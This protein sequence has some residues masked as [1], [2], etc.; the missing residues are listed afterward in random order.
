M[1]RK[2]SENVLA[3]ELEIQVECFYGSQSVA[4]K[5]NYCFTSVDTILNN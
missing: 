1:D 4:A 2:S 3:D 5:I